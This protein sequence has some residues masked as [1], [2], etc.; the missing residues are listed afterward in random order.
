[1][2]EYEMPILIQGPDLNQSTA[3]VKMKALKFLQFLNSCFYFQAFN[4]KL[5]PELCE[6]LYCEHKQALDHG[7]PVVDHF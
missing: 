6:R 5:F 4:A 3:L 2:G 1:M 7:H